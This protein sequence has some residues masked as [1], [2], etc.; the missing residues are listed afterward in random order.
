MLKNSK[1][2]K[3]IVEFACLQGVTGCVE[4]AKKLFV[5]WMRTRSSEKQDYLD[6]F[7][8]KFN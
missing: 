7:Y 3:S 6:K 5:D 8:L 1:I 2:R 4:T